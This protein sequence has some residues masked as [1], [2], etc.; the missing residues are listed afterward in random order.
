MGRLCRGSEHWHEARRSVRPPAWGALGRTRAPLALLL[1]VAARDGR[2]VRQALDEFAVLEPPVSRKPDWSA[3][4]AGSTWLGRLDRQW[5]TV[6]FGTPPLL[7]MLAAVPVAALTHAYLP[8]LVLVMVALLIVAVRMLL[9]LMIVTLSVLQTGH[10][11]QPRLAESHNDRVRS[12]HWV[13]SLMHV[14]T[15][16]HADLLLRIALARSHDLADRYFVPDAADGTHAVMCLDQAITTEPGRRAVAAASSAVEAERGSGVFVVRQGGRFKAPQPEAKRPVGGLGVMLFGTVAVVASASELVAD[17]E[18]A[19]CGNTC[20]GR[21]A[22]WPDASLWLVHRLTYTHSGLSA[23]TFEGRTI[24]LLVAVLGLVLLAVALST[25]WYHGRYLRKRSGLMYSNLERALA[26]DRRILILVALEVERDAVLAALREVGLTQAPE[27]DAA[28]DHAFFRLGRLGRADLLIAQCE[29]GTAGP[30]GAMLTAQV[31]IERLEPTHV[32]L[33]GICYGLWSRGH[34]NGTQQLGDVVVSSHVITLEHRKVTDDGGK[35][36]TREVSRGVRV[37]AS[38]TLLSA[39]R[40]ATATWTGVTVHVG[41]ILS[42]NTLVADRSLRADLRRRHEEAAGGEME[43][44]GVYPAAA[45]TQCE[46]IMVKGISDW[47]LGDLTADA[48]HLAAANAARF[49]AHT[50]ASA[51]IPMPIGRST[52]RS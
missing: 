43:L 4:A 3:C 5:D 36:S 1:Y 37:E 27:Q 44:A 20:G 34:D 11:P 31:L 7:L 12:H 24:G 51:V 6:V 10:G 26:A 23:A 45:R 49:T 28:A 41:A 18:H 47:G 46:W 39:F 29:Q 35:G 40:A 50:L 52:T 33:V 17:R 13:I 30:G 25:L 38:N 8:S 21:P 9:G 15:P 48:R 22:S 2:L 14:E 19:A 16:D 42:W 32:V